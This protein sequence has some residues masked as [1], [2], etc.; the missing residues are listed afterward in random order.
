VCDVNAPVTDG[1]TL[2]TMTA[3]DA[4]IA[5]LAALTKTPAYVV[6]AAFDEFALVAHDA[7]FVEG[8]STVW[9]RLDTP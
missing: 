2:L 6:R 7:N 8:Y 4:A 1:A 9:G 5:K 3:R